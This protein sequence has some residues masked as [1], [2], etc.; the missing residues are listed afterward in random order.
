MN[1]IIMF[2]W[3][4]PFLILPGGYLLFRLKRGRVI[5]Y[6][7]YFAIL[8][9]SFLF[10]LTGT[11]FR[12]DF[13]DILLFLGTTLTLCE[14]FWWLHFIK[15]KTL[16]SVVFLGALT[17]FILSYHEWIL[18]GP[19]KISTLWESEI[20]DSFKGK[21][22]NY[23]I[24][25]KKNIEDGKT[26]RVFYLYKEMNSPFFEQI[27]GLFTVPADYKKAIFSFKWRNTAQGVRLDMIGD[28]DTLWTLGEGIS[29]TVKWKLY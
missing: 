11:S 8:F 28:R 17:F 2:L 22:G 21:T 10:D 26:I 3:V 4:V 29:N 23:R 19:Q 12:I 24:K 18:L 16:F 6:W 1:L 9:C 20:V 5:R 7:I 13:F 25:E 27:I 15:N 14:F